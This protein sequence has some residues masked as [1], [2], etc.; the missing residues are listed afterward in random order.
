MHMAISETR[1]AVG[2]EV[3]RSDIRRV[4]TLLGRSSSNRPDSISR[5]GISRIPAY[6]PWNILPVLALCIATL[7]FLTAPL[8]ENDMFIHIMMGRDIL[9]HGRLTGDPGWTYGTVDESWVTLV[10]WPTQVLMAWGWDFA[11]AGFFVAMR[12]VLMGVFVMGVFWAGYELAGSRRTSVE[13]SRIV[14]VA[15]V[16][17]AALMSPFIVARAQSIAL[18]FT[19]LLAVWFVRALTTGSVG[20]RWWLVPL[21]TWALVWGH[22]TALLVAPLLAVAGAIWWATR[23][24]HFCRSVWRRLAG[25]AGVIALTAVVPALTPIGWRVWERAWKIR[26]VS[27]GWIVEWSPIGLFSIESVYVVVLLPIMAMAVTS[28]WKAGSHKG[29]S[30]RRHA[31]AVALASVALLGVGAIQQRNFVVMIPLLLLMSCAAIIRGAPPLRLQKF[32]SRASQGG[33]LPGMTIILAG[34][35]CMFAV[36]GGAFAS[37]DTEARPILL[38][39]RMAIADGAGERNVFAAMHVAAIVPFYS[40]ADRVAIDARLDR[41]PRKTLL[42]AYHLIYKPTPGWEEDLDEHFP[43]TTDLL[44]DVSTPLAELARDSDHWRVRDQVGAWI[45]I[46]RATSPRS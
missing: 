24:R 36:L 45:W 28:L 15:V 11:G 22:G 2:R 12:A 29:S 38:A 46:E 7:P 30:Y 31:V 1:V 8:V 9:E 10:Q 41:Y 25:L 23:P 35:T 37:L 39:Q 43:G 5:Y 13:A 34:F 33:Y 21:A 40:P 3:R 6:S 19:P 27:E 16:V 17:S 44:L 4:R 14:S 32:E 20:K 42:D 26:E 18:A